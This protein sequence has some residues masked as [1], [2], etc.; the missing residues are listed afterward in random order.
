MTTPNNRRRK[1]GQ[2]RNDDPAI[3]PE[4]KEF[5]ADSIGLFTAFRNRDREISLPEANALMRLRRSQLEIERERL[6]ID[7]E[8]GQLVDV[9]KLTEWR[10][11]IFI[12]LG[13]LVGGSWIAHVFNEYGVSEDVGKAMALD[14]H[15]GFRRMYEST[16]YRVFGGMEG[17]DND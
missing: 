12:G 14:L 3:T 4:M 13:D 1:T 17:G 5:A 8:L 7:R 15:N 2:L 6:A 9:A 11:L 16:T 10:G